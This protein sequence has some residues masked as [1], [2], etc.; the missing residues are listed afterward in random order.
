MNPWNGPGAIHRALATLVVAVA[1]WGGTYLWAQTALQTRAQGLA[2]QQEAYARQ[3]ALAEARRTLTAFGARHAQLRAHGIIGP[4]TPGWDEERVSR[5][6]VR[7]LRFEQA[8]P[9]V[10]RINTHVVADVHPA[11]L[12]LGVRHEREFLAFIDEL[13]R[14]T[15][16]VLRLRTCTLARAE[17][18]IGLT[19]RCRLERLMV[20]ADQEHP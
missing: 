13:A 7:D 18:G 9:Y 20:R 11:E 10:A 3:A 15:P 16:G 4:A 8:A 2:Q 19:A 6:P 12:S 14:I 5:I 1:A 17:Q